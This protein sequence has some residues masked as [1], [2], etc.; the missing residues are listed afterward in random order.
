MHV[1]IEHIRASREPTEEIKQLVKDKLNWWKDRPTQ[2][3]VTISVP[4]DVGAQSQIEWL[5]NMWRIPYKVKPPL[6]LM[7]ADEALIG[8]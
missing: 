2:M 5:L 7:Y 6:I 1:T 4:I 3:V 8:E